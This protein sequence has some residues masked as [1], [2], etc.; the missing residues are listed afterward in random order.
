ME[1]TEYMRRQAVSEVTHHGRLL[2][3]VARQYGL[4]TKS[5]YLLVRQSES[6]NQSSAP[7]LQRLSSA[8]AQLNARIFN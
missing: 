4:S 8:I 7:W 3:D 2:C 5:L 6:D 1:M